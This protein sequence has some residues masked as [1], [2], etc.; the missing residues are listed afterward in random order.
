[1][2]GYLGCVDHGPVPQTLA[3]TAW[4]AGTNIAYRRDAMLRAGGFDESLGRTGRNLLSNEEPAGLLVVY[5]PRM[6]VRHRVGPDRL[7]PAWMRTR[8]AWQVVSN[9]LARPDDSPPARVQDI[10]SVRAFLARFPGGDPGPEALFA[11]LPDA[12][13]ALAQ[14]V[15]IEA[16]VRLLLANAADWRTVVDLDGS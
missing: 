6:R 11:D 10:A 9:L 8:S 2:L 12:R 13:A 4:L 7:S 14:L 3:P 15:A 5:D 16:L 1:M